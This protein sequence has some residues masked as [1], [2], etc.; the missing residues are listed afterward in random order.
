[1]GFPQGFTSIQSKGDSTACTADI[2]SYTPGVS[3]Y[4]AI[5][6]KPAPGYPRTLLDDCGPPTGLPSF[7]IH[8][9]YRKFA[10]ERFSMIPSVEN[11]TPSQIL[12]LADLRYQFFRSPDLCLADLCFMRMC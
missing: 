7:G 8:L 5:F 2:P 9:V 1:M 10:G 11:P 12:T 4:F 6:G 3:R